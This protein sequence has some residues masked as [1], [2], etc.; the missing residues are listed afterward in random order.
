MKTRRLAT[1]LSAAVLLSLFLGTPAVSQ[2][3]EE[4]EIRQFLQQRFQDDIHR[5]TWQDPLGMDPCLTDPSFYPG[6]SRIE[7]PDQYRPLIPDQ[8]L[9]PGTLSWN[10]LEYIL[11]FARSGTC[12]LLGHIAPACEE[13]LEIV[14]PNPSSGL[15]WS[16]ADPEPDQR[17]VYQ[18]TVVEMD[19]ATRVM[20]NVM[21]QRIERIEKMAEAM[22][23]KVMG[24]EFEEGEGRPSSE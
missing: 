8:R 21:A 18:T 11:P 15:G 7:Y 19:V 4:W 5:R 22:Y 1:R 17:I 24:E 2:D 14:E 10:Y 9:Y 13:L 3:L 6:H 12:G 16:D 23:L 20:L